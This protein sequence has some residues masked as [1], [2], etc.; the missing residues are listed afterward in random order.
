MDPEIKENENCNIYSVK[1]QRSLY[2]LQQSGWMWYNRLSEFLLKKEYIN[3]D[4]YPCVFKK[5]LLN[6]F[7]IISVYAGDINIIGTRKEI[8]KASSCLNMEFEIED[9]GKTKYCPNL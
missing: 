9:L 1:L 6:D 4:A 2:G 3:N 8:E 5:K 7:C